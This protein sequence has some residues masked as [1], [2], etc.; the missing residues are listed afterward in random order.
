MGLKIWPARK[1]ALMHL[2]RLVSRDKLLC[3]VQQCN[4][5][6]RLSDSMEMFCWCPGTSH[7]HFHRSVFVPIFNL[8][9]KTWMEMAGILRRQTFPKKCLMLSGGGKAGIWKKRICNKDWHWCCGTCTFFFPAALMSY[10]HT[11][12]D[13]STPPQCPKSGRNKKSMVLREC[14]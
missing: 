3:S 4:T 10:C 6:E 1:S 2:F 12:L 5:A 7:K 14:T 8:C 11:L 9:I 13:A